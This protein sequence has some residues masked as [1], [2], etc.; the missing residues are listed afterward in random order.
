MVI[1][2]LGDT[3][4]ILITGASSGIGY[5]VGVMLA[6]RGHLVYMT[7]R[8]V[9][10]V[11]C[12]REKLMRETVSAICLKLDLLT[13][14]IYLANSLDIDCLFNHAGIGSSG[15]ILTMDEKGIRDVYETNIFRSFL[16]LKLV[17]CHMMK[18]HIKGKIFVTSSLL[19][20]YPL[21][22]LG[23]YS[24]SKSAISSFV[25]ALQWE[26]RVLNCSISFCLVEPGAYFTGFNQVMIDNVEKYQD[27]NLKFLSI[28]NYQRKLFLLLESRDVGRLAN[29]I[30]KEMEK[31]KPKKVLRF[32][33]IQGI[34]LKIYF[35]LF[36]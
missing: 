9:R 36:G 16:F 13:D 24:S 4:R 32:P 27:L 2:I 7:C 26:S 35:L 20:I 12:L 18:R 6:K 34:L 14:D 28:H 23:V 1:L 11:F 19:S 21:P 30:V 17:S 25:K 22:F 15:S 10:E 3:M 8:T 5:Q 33:L 31:E 29:K